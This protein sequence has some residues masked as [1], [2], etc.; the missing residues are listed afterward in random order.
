MDEILA[1][2]AA[3]LSRT[4]Y[5][6]EPIP[7][8][9]GTLA[10]LEREAAE[11]ERLLRDGAGYAKRSWMDKLLKRPLVSLPASS[12]VVAAKLEALKARR[13]ELSTKKLTGVLVPLTR[14]DDAVRK[15]YYYMTRRH[16]VASLPLGP[17]EAAQQAREEAIDFT[18]GL[19]FNA[20]NVE[21]VLKR[22]EGDKL[23]PALTEAEAHKLHPNV[24]KEVLLQHALAFELT[25][26]EL[27]KSA[28]P[29]MAGSAI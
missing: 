16:L 11:L 18:C 4:E 5:P 13:A 21:L 29:M 8:D 24:A 12:A 17:D 9:S 19:Y 7:L 25:E 14:Q 22:R 10:A 28:A 3:K 6:L 26:E 15:A 23:V 27:G 20:K 1:S 2:A